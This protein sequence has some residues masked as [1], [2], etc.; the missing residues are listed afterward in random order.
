[1]ILSQNCCSS[2]GSES[3]GAQLMHDYDAGIV[4][5]A[6]AIPGRGW[7]HV[8]YEAKGGFVPGAVT[9]A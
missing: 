7:L 1:V 8:S 5:A 4:T 9:E 6:P 2:C 3:D